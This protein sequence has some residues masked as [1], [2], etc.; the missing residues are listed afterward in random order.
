M[1]SWEPVSLSWRTVLHGVSKWRYSSPLWFFATLL[2][3]SHDR[4]NW[5]FPSF[6]STTFQ[7]FP[8]ISDL[9]SQLPKFQQHTN[10][11][12]KCS[13]LLVSSFIFSP[14]CWWRESSY[15][16]LLCHDD[17]PYNTFPFYF[18]SITF[19]VCDYCFEFLIASVFLFPHSLPFQGI[20]PILI[21][22]SN[23]ALAL[24]CGR[25]FA[26]IVGSNPTGVMDVCL[27]WV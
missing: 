16:T 27:F 25:S 23:Q 2:H 22:L 9:L 7:N 24:A 17:P 1:T 4:A 26:G 12:S 14:I 10:I 18:L 5:S 3:F 19:C 21:S 8:V 11:C 15:W 13:S 20:F 6:S